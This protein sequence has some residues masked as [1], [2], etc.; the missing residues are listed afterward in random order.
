[1]KRQNQSGT[2]NHSKVTSSKR[3]DIS[4]QHAPRRRP[5]SIPS[6]LNIPDSGRDDHDEQTNPEEVKEAAEVAVIALRIEVR[7]AGHIVD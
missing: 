6:I 3:P 2:S 5:Q 1:M 4:H 7:H